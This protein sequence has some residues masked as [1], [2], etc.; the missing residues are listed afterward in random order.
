MLAEFKETLAADVVFLLDG[1]HDPQYPIEQ[2]G[3]LSNELSEKFRVLA[4]I[5][6]LS[7]AKTDT[8][9]HNLIRSVQCR[10]RYLKRSQDENYL[11]DFYRAS[12]RNEAFFDALAASQFDVARNIA[13]LSPKH[14]FSENE[15][16]EDYCYS[17]VLYRLLVDDSQAD[18]SDVNPLVARFESAGGGARLEICKSFMAH[19]QESFHISFR[20]LLDERDLE[21]KK[22][23]ERGQM[24]D[25]KVM[26][27][28]EIFIEGLGILRLAEKLEFPT[29]REY[30]YCPLL[31]R[32]PMRTPFTE[33]V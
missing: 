7:E 17:Q 8:F 22:A 26:A 20:A 32:L 3:R 15:Y 10:Q 29:E 16:E 1:L 30:R 14:W 28:R 27:N 18:S 11:A 31:A 2:L 21:I 9:Y 33:I 12:S 25:V 6:L 19:D 24:E 5:L 4:I 23:K 13:Q